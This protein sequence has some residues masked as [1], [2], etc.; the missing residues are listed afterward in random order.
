MNKKKHIKVGVVIQARMGST[1]LPGKVMKLLGDRPVLWHVVERVKQS[2]LI[3]MI[4]V[5]TTNSDEDNTIVEFCKKNSINYY[6]GSEKDVLDRYYKTAKYYKL[7][8]IIRVTSDCPIIDSI[9]IDKLVKTY[10]D[11]K[12]QLDYVSNSMIRTYPRGLECSIFSMEALKESWENATKEYHKEHVVMY[13]R[14]HKE[15]FKIMNI[16]NDKMLSNYR[17]T[18]DTKEDYIFLKCIYN[19]L[20][21]SGSIFTTNDVLEL[22]KEQ[23]EL[24]NINAHVEQKKVG[25]NI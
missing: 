4:I 16:C 8:A 9:V 22:L 1:R 24:I 3:D 20:Y 18:L 21:K 2:K 25:A 23:P 7:D 15:K 14:E 5:A 10:L 13:I 12:E 6:R 19:N 11:N 17:W